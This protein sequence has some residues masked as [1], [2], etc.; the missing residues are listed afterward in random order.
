MELDDCAFPLLK[1]ITC[2]HHLSVAFKDA[3][4]AILVGSVPRKAGME[5]ADLL[6][7]MVESLL[8]KVKQLTITLL[9][10]FEFLLS[11]TLVTQTVYRYEQCPESS[12]R[13]FLCNDNS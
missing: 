5:R 7:L 4:W 9:M 3:N 10:T 13:S 1:K 12:K 6:K 8:S 11:V 2:T